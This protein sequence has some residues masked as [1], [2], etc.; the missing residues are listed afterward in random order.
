M[1]E[2]IIRYYFHLLRGSIFYNVLLL[3]RNIDS[4]LSNGII[5]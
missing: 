4:N 5:E 2:T 1:V 3:I